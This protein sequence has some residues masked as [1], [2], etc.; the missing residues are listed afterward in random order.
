[1]FGYEEIN[2]HL[3]YPAMYFIIALI[4]IGGYSYYVYRFTIPPVG[5]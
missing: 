5:K 4:L 1:M 3:T 2:L